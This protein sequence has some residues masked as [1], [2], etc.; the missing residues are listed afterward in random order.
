MKKRI[1]IAAGIVVLSALIL[2]VFLFGKGENKNL[3]RTTGIVETTEVNISSKIPGR[4]SELCCKEGDIVKEGGVII[5]LE[6]DDIT[7]SVEQARA[8]VERARFDLKVSETVIEN[9]RANISS[10][11]AEIKNAE[12]EVE[13]ARLQMEE[14]GRGMK[15]ADA[16][17]K[18]GFISKADMDLKV[19]SYGT[20]VSAYEASKAR[21]NA[22]VSK[23]DAAKAQLNTSLSQFNSSK[24][25][26][27][28]SKAVL[29][30]QI[31]K[32]ND[33]VIKTPIGGTVVF[34][35]IEKGETVT[36]G[37]MLLTIAD[38]NNLWIRIDLEE[39]II[40]AIHLGDDVII[41][42]ESAKDKTF[43]GSIM[44][45]GRYAEFATQK[46]VTRGRQDIKT[47]R[48]KIKTED[49]MGILKPGMTVDIN[50]PV[51]K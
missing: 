25:R 23:K 30:Y 40:G 31:A 6:S 1:I 44:E 36:A 38:L 26:L 46:D 41:R 2:S 22:V 39:T 7:A 33:T 28:E 17:F 37:T 16:L 12:A 27:K 51:K 47:F 50:I 15:R 13:V 4:I 19:T 11:E 3:L 18:E 9:S 43:K 10:S 32:L 48:V 42:I 49:T 29:L 34:K 5:R 8:G 21:L 14:A 24:A 35:A 45:I 20:S